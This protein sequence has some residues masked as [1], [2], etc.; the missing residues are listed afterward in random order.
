MGR[1]P[2]HRGGIDEETKWVSFGDE[3]KRLMDEKGLKSTTLAHDALVPAVVVK[4][5]RQSR[6]VSLDHLTNIARVLNVNVSNI[7]KPIPEPS[8][9]STSV[10]NAAEEF[11]TKNG[12]ASDVLALIT[13]QRGNKKIAEFILLE[14][15]PLKKYF[16]LILAYLY[17][18]ESTKLSEN[19]RRGLRAFKDFATMLSVPRDDLEQVH[20]DLARECVRVDA[21]CNETLVSYL[22]IARALA[23]K[24]PEA[25]QSRS[26]QS[27]AN[28]DCSLSITDR[29]H[30]WLIPVI[31]GIP[32]LA[33]AGEFDGSIRPFT[34]GLARLFPIP[35]TTADQVK[36]IKRRLGDYRKQHRFVAAILRE[37]QKDPIPTI[38]R[39]FPDLIVIVLPKTDDK[40]YTE[41]L[42]W[43][44][45]IES[46]INNA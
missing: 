10:L 2:K 7:G 35:S 39:T 30:Q 27:L 22:I 12:D 28:D 9:T 41:I 13:A 44:Q 33:D 15:D 16:D 5:A 38:H 46:R 34:E 21:K 43:R 29:N 26:I 37:N 4:D 3:I 42:G 31:V 24:E 11:L 14:K 1:L 19:A 8:I 18:N 23:E 17:P 36:E 40:R 20:A 6:N 45:D 32:Q 25:A